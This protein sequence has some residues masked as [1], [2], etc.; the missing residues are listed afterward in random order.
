MIAFPV[1]ENFCPEPASRT[2]PERREAQKL[3]KRPHATAI[4]A[5]CGAA[6]PTL[7]LSRF[8]LAANNKAFTLHARRSIQSKD[9]RHGHRFA[10]VQVVEICKTCCLRRIRR[11]RPR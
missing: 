8:Q 2:G 4:E 1:V 3:E 7:S 6:W 11:W 10:F 9:P 5:T